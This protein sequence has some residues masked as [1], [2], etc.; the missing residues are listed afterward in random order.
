MHK[1]V[2]EFIGTFFLVLVI[3]LAVVK[4]GIHAP[5]AIGFA[6]MVLVYMGANISGSH[7]NP[8]VTLAILIRGAIPAGEAGGYMVSQVLG[9]IAGA[10]TASF[11]VGPEFGAPAVASGVGA[12][13][14]ILV[15]ILFT[16]A[17]CSVVLNTATTKAAEG[18]S[19]FGLAIGCTVLV[20][21]Y[22]GGGI[23]GGAFNPAVGIGGNLIKGSFGDVWI[24]VVGP[25]LG[26][27]LAALV[28]K[29]CNPDEK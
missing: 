26:G 22:A 8:A 18:N 24:Y 11:L 28:F 2:N 14:A 4:A 6:L 3:G 27:V 10:A 21:A 19:Y 5:L 13:P 23:S 20:G 9:G 1:F 7:Y 17:L 29:I 16:Y 12:A 15:E 25:L